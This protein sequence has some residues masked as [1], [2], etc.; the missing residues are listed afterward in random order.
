M[1]AKHLEQ[2]EERPNAFES[3]NKLEILPSSDNYFWELPQ[4]QQGLIIV[5]DWLDSQRSGFERSALFARYGLEDGQLKNM[6]ATLDKLGI[7]KAPHNKQKLSRSLDI[8]EA[9]LKN[10]LYD[11]VPRMMMMFKNF[12]LAFVIEHTTP[13]ERW[14]P[15]KTNWK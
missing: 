15:A 1:Y 13:S 5:E 10:T 12:S 7:K 14:D 9:N 8:S 11:R 4:F 2:L 3:K 6:T